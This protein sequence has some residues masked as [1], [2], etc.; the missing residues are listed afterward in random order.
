MTSPSAARFRLL[1]PLA[2][3]QI[4][5]WGT[6]FDMPGALGRIIAADLG[7]SNEAAFAGL[8]VMMIVSG[9]AGPWAGRL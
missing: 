8:S 2:L 4:I 5:G 9:L 7:F 1:A 6:T 3:C